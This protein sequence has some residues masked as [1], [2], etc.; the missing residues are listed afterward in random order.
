MQ[1]QQGF[2]LVEM[3]V[4]VAI[5]GIVTAIAMPAYQDYVLTG[6]A[7]EA[8]ANL[9]NCRVQAE[10]YFQDNFT[11]VGYVCAPTDAKYFS[12]SISNQSATTYTL[13]ATGNTAQNMSNFQFSVDQNNAKTSVFKGTAGN[14]CWLTSASGSC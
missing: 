9:A 8:T 6:N 10:Q 5:I 2:S 11:Y 12:Y 13:V 14:T 7:T 4:V 1:N 3:M